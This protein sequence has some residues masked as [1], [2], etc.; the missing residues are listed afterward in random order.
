MKISQPIAGVF[1]AALLSACG[2]GGGGGAT[3]TNADPQGYWSGPTST[4]YTANLAVLEN[5]EIWGVYSSGS[6]IYV[7]LYGTSSVS[8]NNI[9]ATGTDFNFV[10]NTATPGTVTGTFTPKSSLSLK[11]ANASLALVFQ[12]SY[13]TPATS[14]AITGTWSFTG[15]SGSYT[16]MPGTITVNSAGN[17]TLNQ[18][19]CTTSGSIVPRLGGK[20]I[21][22][23]NLT[24]S[25][26]GCAVGQSSM[27]GIVYLDATVT[28]NK[29][30]SLA[31]TPN[32]NDG[33]IVIGT[34]Q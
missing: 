26:S 20:N 23:V 18:S 24:A 6:V 2:G 16:L 22:N 5:G 4:G 25:G 14:A 19:T 30:L 21:Y 10:T 27:S 11:N 29:F 1:L 32:K 33:V 8:G 17:F 31:L 7:A 34:K 9:A 3:T 12:P 13:D 15:R 28:P